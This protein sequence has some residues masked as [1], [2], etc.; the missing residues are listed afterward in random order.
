MA[1]MSH[2]IPPDTDEDVDK[3]NSKVQR[4]RSEDFNPERPQTKRQKRDRKKS[5]S[6]TTQQQPQQTYKCPHCEKCFKSKM[7]LD[8]HV[9]HWVCRIDE[10][11]DPKIVAQAKKK[12][13]K[14]KTKT[15]NEVSKS[16][17][18][19]AKFRG[20]LNDRICPHCKR[21]F[22]SILGMKYHTGKNA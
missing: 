20:A 7:G 21:V 8:Y 6:K 10:C 11:P 1:T 15:D 9:E 16:T 3:D 18:K 17:G 22:T 12:R 19:K 5:S 4:V 14:T 13:G 2:I